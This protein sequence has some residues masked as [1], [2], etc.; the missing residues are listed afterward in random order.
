MKYEE[1]YAL[2]VKPGLRFLPGMESPEATALLLAI[3]M[4]ESRFEKRRQVVG[5]GERGKPLYGP[6]R[7][8]Y[9]FED[10]GGVLGVLRHHKTKDIILHILKVLEILPEDSLQAITFNDALATVFARLLLYTDPQK[11]PSL[12]SPPEEAWQ[13]YVR[14]WRPGKPHRHTWDAYLLHSREFVRQ[15]HGSIYDPLIA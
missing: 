14:N 11:L 12:T 7:G 15:I 13:Y 1:A 2:V 8:F 5:F 3:G 4:Q 9:Q 10:G 6:A